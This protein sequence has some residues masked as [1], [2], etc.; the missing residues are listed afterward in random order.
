MAQR[1]F[2]DIAK[3]YQAVIDGEL[4]ITSTGEIW[5]VGKRVWSRWENSTVLRTC[6]RVRAE[7]DVIEY[8]MI[9]VMYDKKR[10]CAG[11][12]RLVYY[13]FHGVIPEGMT[14]NHKDGNKKNNHPDNL[15]LMTDQE[16]CL[17]ARNVLGVGLLD[18]DGEKNAMSKLTHDQVVEIRSKRASGIPLK[19]I[20]DEYNI[21]FQTVS[22]IARN[23]RWKDK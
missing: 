6:K 15:E 22:K 12:H 16:Q 19:T 13:H 11:A 2:A 8:L 7:K 10:L 5:R 14:V 23:D 9:R 17:H 3:I 1:K 21:S 18:Q 4:E 20:A